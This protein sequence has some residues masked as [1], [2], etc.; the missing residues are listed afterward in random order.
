MSIVFSIIFTV[1]CSQDMALVGAWLSGS[2][3]IAV[4]A[5]PRLRQQTDLYDPQSSL[6]RVSDQ[7]S[8]LGP[9]LLVLL[10]N[11]PAH[12]LQTLLVVGLRTEVD[13]I[14]REAGHAT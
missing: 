7:Q 6:H 12:F 14:G 4:G 3:T 1:Q 5:R 9:H 2:V 8:F 13:D 11:K 10:V